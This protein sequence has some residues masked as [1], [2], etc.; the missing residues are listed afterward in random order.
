VYAKKIDLM[1]YWSDISL[2]H[3]E[4][5]GGFFERFVSM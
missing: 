5:E 3:S 1:I 4:I 2:G